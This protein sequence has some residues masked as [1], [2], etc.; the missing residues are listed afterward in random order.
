MLSRLVIRPIDAAARTRSTKMREIDPV[1]RE[2]PGALRSVRHGWSEH[3]QPDRVLGSQLQIAQTAGVGEP[4]SRWSALL[5]TLV[6]LPFACITVMAAVITQSPTLLEIGI[7]WVGVLGLLTV[8]VQ[9]G[10]A[11]V[12]HHAARF[13]PFPRAWAS[14]RK[15]R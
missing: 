8:V 10:V 6:S 9:L 3:V 14:T 7:G 4:I 13:A 2:S 5:V 11:L 12:N 15:T 1:H